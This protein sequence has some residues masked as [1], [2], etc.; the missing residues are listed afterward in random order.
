LLRSAKIFAL[1]NSKFVSF[2]FQYLH[3]VVLQSYILADHVKNPIAPS[4]S[5][6]T[7]IDALCH[8][9]T[10]PQTSKPSQSFEL[11]ILASGSV[12]KRR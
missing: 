11:I 2:Q 3:L 12:A 9:K 1:A 4:N 10:S 8:Q 5:L 7:Q 6:L